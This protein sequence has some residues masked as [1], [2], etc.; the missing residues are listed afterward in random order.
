MTHPGGDGDL[1]TL[2]VSSD[3]ADGDDQPADG[4]ALCLSGGGYRAMLF[5]AGAFIRLAEAGQLGSVQRVSSVSGGSIA[6]AAL[7]LAWPSLKDAKF[8]GDAVRDNVVALLLEQAKRRIDVPAAIMSF[9]P[10]ITASGWVAWRYRKLLGKK[11]LQD[12]PNDPPR[13]VF[14]ATNLQSLALFRFSKPY[15]QDYKVGRISD[16]AIKLTKVVA[17]SSAFPPFLSPAR[18]K[19][20]DAALG[21]APGAFLNKEPYSTR[22][23]LSDGGVY[24]NL[25][26]ETAWKRYRTVLVSDGGGMTA[27]SERVPTFWPTQMYRVMMTIDHQV[28]SLRKRAVIASYRSGLRTGAYWGIRTDIS[29]YELADALP[30]PLDQTSTLAH[31]ATG[32][33]P[34][35]QTTRHRLVNWGYAVCDAAVRAHVDRSLPPPAVFPFPDEA[36]GQQQ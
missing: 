15:A 14:N 9:A 20:G 4:V 32:L 11:T 8:T 10:G 30:C 26:L 17:A 1:D 22:P 27:P 21:P 28:R 31:I 34:L 5:H 16:P 13:F 35:N 7:A 12:L 18:L 29:H 19:L 25:G 36:V 2:A 24:D 3:P 23:V 6:A 33:R